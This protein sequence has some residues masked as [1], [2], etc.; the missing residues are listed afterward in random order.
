MNNMHE[1]DL[2]FSITLADISTCETLCH[3]SLSVE[4]RSLWKEKEAMHL[5]STVDNSTIYC[6]ASKTLVSLPCLLCSFC[7]LVWG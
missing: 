7:D 5:N 4:L 1:G 6:R 3:G 2:V